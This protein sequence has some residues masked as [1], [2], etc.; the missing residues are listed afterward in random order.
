MTVTLYII[1]DGDGYK[2][3]NLPIVRLWEPESISRTW[4]RRVT[5]N[6]PDGFRV[7]DN[8]YEEPCLYRGNQQY[9]LSTDK[10]D[11][12]VIIDHLNNGAYIHL[13]VLAEGWDE[14]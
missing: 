3:G 4:I 5:V 11:N 10:A 1:K 13:T 2:F 6:L 9:E 14:T 8:V 7:A 12:P